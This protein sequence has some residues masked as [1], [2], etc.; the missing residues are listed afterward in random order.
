MYSDT[1]RKILVNNLTVLLTHFLIRNIKYIIHIS[2]AMTLWRKSR[3]H[4]HHNI[5]FIAIIEVYW[6]LASKDHKRKFLV[7][8]THVFIFVSLP[9]R[10]IV[11]YFS[12]VYFLVQWHY[13][14]HRYTCLQVYMVFKS[15][16][17]PTANLFPASSN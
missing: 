7:P 9:K 1:C 11:I 10:Y 2:S 3:T 16:F 4:I 6:F 14:I 8:P 17:S 5:L 13:Y 12:H 15:N